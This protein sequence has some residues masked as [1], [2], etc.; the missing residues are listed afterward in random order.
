MKIM[1]LTIGWQNNIK[2]HGAEPSRYGDWRVYQL[3]AGVYA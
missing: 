1:Q 2:A 3:V